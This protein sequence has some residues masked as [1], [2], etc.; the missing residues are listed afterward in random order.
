MDTVSGEGAR[1]GLPRWRLLVRR[2]LFF[3]LTAASACGAS[4]LLLDVLMANGVTALELLGLLLFFGLFFWISGALWTAI[5]GFAIQLIGRDRG[6]IDWHAVA[7]RALTT[8]TAVVMPIYNE[9]TQRVEAGL[10]AIW[11]SL[12]QQSEQHAFDLFILSD[13]GAGDIAVQEEA[14]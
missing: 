7:G 9:D 10:A 6:N 11:Q 13:S 12:A 8:R 4:A 2:T 1:A 5:A 3:S 14:M